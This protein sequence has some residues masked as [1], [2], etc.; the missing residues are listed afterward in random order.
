MNIKRLESFCTPF[1]GFL[2]VTLDDD[3]Q[4][5]GQFSTY[6]SDITA[7]IFHRQVAPWVLGA[8]GLHPE[9]GAL[10]AKVEEREHKFPGSYLKR[11]LAGLDTALWDL[12]GKRAGLPVAAL[13]GGA[14]HRSIRAYA[15]SMRR[16][17]T[18]MAEA[19]RFKRLRDRYGFDAF[20]FRI[21]SECGH[22]LDEWEGRTEAIIPI[23]R[24]ALGPDV[25]LLVDANGGFSAGRA[26]AVGR[27]LEQEGVEHFEEP[28]LYWELDD[29]KQVTDA[30]A[31]NVAGGEQDCDLPLWKRICRE[32]IVDIAQPDILYA[33]GLTRVLTIARLAAAAGIVV[34]PHAAN[35]GLVTLFTMHLLSALPNA[36]DYLEFSIEDKDYYPWQYGLFRRDPY[37]VENG[38]LTLSAEPGWG[39][40]ISPNWLENAK[41]QMSEKD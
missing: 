40:E 11:A 37:H 21:G 27:M 30:L 12:A 17:I 22:D 18:P 39:I 26:I 38:H 8:C 9:T 1:I 15:S 14:Y 36:G 4:G 24:Q 7:T 28:C 6:N 16:D 41:Y 33:G 29:T 19:E 35:L 34:T 25:A 31:I 32:H 13:L 3:T 5:W 2:R 23:I 20:K 10:V